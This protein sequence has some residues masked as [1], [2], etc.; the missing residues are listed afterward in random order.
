MNRTAYS[1]RRYSLVSFLRMLKQ[2]LC[3]PIRHCSVWVDSGGH[4][5]S[6]TPPSWL[7]DSYLSS[8]ASYSTFRR[9]RSCVC[10]P[11]DMVILR[12]LGKYTDTTPRDYNT[13][14]IR[15]DPAIRIRKKR[16]STAHTQFKYSWDCML[17]IC[18]RRCFFLLNN[19]LGI[20][21]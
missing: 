7:F 16:R 18:G 3:S 8:C 1:Y 9:Q 15:G 5:E 6:G 4:R 14:M 12:W 10:C 20:R 19:E 11:A 21:E 13:R 2:G 17:S